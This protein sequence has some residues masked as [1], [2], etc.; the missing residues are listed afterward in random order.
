MKVL[1]LIDSLHIGGAERVA[2]TYANMLAREIEGSY[3]CATREEGVLKE[4]LSK[5][6]SYLFLEKKKSLDMRAIRVLTQFIKKE[7]ITHVHAHGT[8]Y[9]LATLVKMRCSNLKLIWHNHHGASVQLKGLKLRVLKLCSRYFDC[10]FTVNNDLKKWAVQSLN[11]RVVEYVP[12]FVSFR[13]SKKNIKP[14]LAGN[15]NKRVIYLANLRGPKNH[16]FL[17]NAFEQVIASVPDATLHLVGNDFNDEYSRKLK[18][19]IESRA[20]INHIFIHGG[21]SNPDSYLNECSIGVIASSSEGLPMSLLE[22]GRAGLAV[23]STNVG[24][25]EE[26][27]GDGGLVVAS[28][29]VPAM[30]NAILNLLKNE[31]VRGELGAKFKTRVKE[32]YALQ[33]V[34][35]DILRIYRNLVENK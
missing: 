10:I 32:R 9:F 29:D 15:R 1:Q 12:N 3:V 17:C 6:V 19:F 34:Q 18:K 33:R 26:V 35:E 13:E 30:K 25:C 2:V 23:V 4:T 8:S 28:N 21:Q 16:L 22:Y 7:S 27:I 5:E 20:L 14:I 11:T 31:R 24:Q